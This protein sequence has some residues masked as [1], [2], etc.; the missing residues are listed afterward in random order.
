MFCLHIFRGFFSIFSVCLEGNIP[1]NYCLSL[2][3]L[4]SLQFLVNFKPFF[5][6]SSFKYCTSAMLATLSPGVVCLQGLSVLKGLSISDV[7]SVYESCIS[8]TIPLLQALVYLYPM[9]I[10]LSDSKIMYFFNV[11]SVH[12]KCVCLSE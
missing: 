7:L 1:P 12:C 9:F 6:P 4:A 5:S 11:L 2:Y 10:F 3:L 8:P